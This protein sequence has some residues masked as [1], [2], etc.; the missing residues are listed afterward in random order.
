MESRKSGETHVICL[1]MGEKIIE[2]LTEFCGKNGIKSGHFSGIGG[3][4]SA[5][6]AYYDLKDRQYHP[7]VFGQPPM[8]LLSLKGN[9]SVDSKGLKIHAHVLIGDST[10]RTFGGHLV[11]GVVSPTCEIILT[12]LREKIERKPDEETGLSLMDL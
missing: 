6:I 12:P 1:K 7:K 10:F 5:E 8:E 3:L 2:K 4:K 9:V 11:E